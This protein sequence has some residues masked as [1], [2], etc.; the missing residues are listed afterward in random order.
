MSEHDAPEDNDARIFSHT[1]HDYTDDNAFSSPQPVGKPPWMTRWCPPHER[2]ESND[3]HI[4]ERKRHGSYD[5]VFSPHDDALAHDVPNDAED[6]GVGEKNEVRVQK[7]RS[8]I[9][10]KRKIL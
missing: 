10:R 6:E 5:D 3:A 1:S 2:F 8:T 9:N 4:G 7:R